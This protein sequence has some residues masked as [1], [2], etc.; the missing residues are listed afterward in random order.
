MNEVEKELRLFWGF[1]VEGFRGLGPCG[2]RV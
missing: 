2:F 1:R